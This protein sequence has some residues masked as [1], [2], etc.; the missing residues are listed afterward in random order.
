MEENLTNGNETSENSLDIYL[1]SNSAISAVSFVL[2]LCCL[3]IFSDSTFRG[4]KLFT[5]LQ[6]QSL[7][8]T[9]SC[10]MTGMTFVLNIQKKWP[11]VRTLPVVVL[12]Q[13]LSIFI[14]NMLAKSELANSIMAA[15][16]CFKLIKSGHGPTQP[17]GNPYL[18]AALMLI[19]V[20]FTSVHEIFQS[21]IQAV[22]ANSYKLVRT[23][24][25]QSQVY[26]CLDIASVALNNGIFSA[27]LVIFDVLIILELRS[28]LNRKLRMAVEANKSEQ[29]RRSRAKLTKT[30]ILECLNTTLC[31]LLIILYF[32]LDNTLPEGVTGS[33]QF[34]STLVLICFSLKFGIFYSF[35]KRFRMLAN[36]K[37]FN[38]CP[39]R[40]A[41]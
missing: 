31:H 26:K 11:L 29:L 13:Y 22:E 12:T 28:S 7:S 6:L 40:I 24:F 8:T 37:L 32:I 14:P 2:N 23:N 21:R 9:A 15:Y 1:I 3:I 4:E 18:I 17:R 41:R 36:R 39:C 19:F 30:M 25:G 5:Y 33:G 38:R 10:F 27:V 16:C 35:N 34:I 20:V